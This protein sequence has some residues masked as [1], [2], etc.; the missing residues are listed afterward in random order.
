MVGSY[1][2]RYLMPRLIFSKRLQFD[3]GNCSFI[4]MNLTEED[5]N[6]YTFTTRHQEQERI[7]NQEEYYNVTVMTRRITPVSPLNKSSHHEDDIYGPLAVC[8]LLDPSVATLTMV[9]HRLL[10]RLARKCRK[11]SSEERRSWLH[12]VFEF[13]LGPP[14]Q[15]ATNG[16]LVFGEHFSLLFQSVGAVLFTVWLADGHGHSAIWA[17]CSAISVIIGIGMKY[18]RCP[19]AGLQTDSRCPC[20]ALQTNSRC[21]CAALQTGLRCHHHAAMLLWPLLT[22]GLIVVVFSLMYWKVAMIRWYWYL[23]AAV[24]SL[25]IRLVLIAFFYWKP[26]KKEEKNRSITDPDSLL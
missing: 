7:R 22:T 12:P 4:L 11:R 17:I 19:C 16:G 24:I 21:P 10:L 8:F 15:D 26:K 3:E 18:S 13:I 2:D 20:A 1:I 9:I 25:S 14:F 23:G 5:S 6:I